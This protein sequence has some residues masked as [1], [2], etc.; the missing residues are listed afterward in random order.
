MDNI[1]LDKTSKISKLGND[2]TIK[3]KTKKDWNLVDDLVDS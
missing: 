1:L 3:R 2:K